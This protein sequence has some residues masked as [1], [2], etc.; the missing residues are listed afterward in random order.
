M[1][2]LAL[3]DTPAGW[4]RRIW[5]LTWPV[6]AANITIPLVGLVDTA[7]MG[8]LP[9]PAFMGAVAVGATVFSALYWIFGF[10]RMG[11]TALAAQAA[12]AGNRTALAAVALRGGSFA[13]LL[14]L[15]ILALQLPLLHLVRWM[16]QAS[17]EVESG[18]ATYFLIRVWG[19]P[20]L[21]LHLV[22]LG[23]LFGLQRMRAVL[24]L[25]ILMNLTN[26][27]LDL[28]LVPGLGWGVAGVATATVASEWLAMLVGARLL[29]RALGGQEVLRARHGLWA[30][31][32]LIRLAGMS[33]N[34]M[35]RSFF[36][37]LP[38]FVFTLVGASLGDL[39]LA[40][41]AILM[42][43]FIAMAY[44][45]DG[46]A[47]TAE[48]LCGYAYGA[49][50]RAGLRDATRHNL[51]WALGL[52]V[53]L[54][55]LM[56]VAG[57]HF[58]AWLTLL[59][60]VRAAAGTLLPWAVAAPL[61]AVWAF[62]LD[63]VFIGTGQARTLR[64]CMLLAALAYLLVI[65]AGL[66]PLGNSGLWLAMMVFMAL[67]GILLGLLYPGIERQLPAPQPR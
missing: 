45:L 67:R 33:G 19:A 18:A 27:A 49:A 37:Q 53:G 21:M 5:D 42:Q 16:F 26:I 64:N 63:G 34:L 47:H 8:R 59:P 66:G 32:S 51:R 41:N 55:L 57:E 20:A 36:V 48:T 39:V 35:V 52:A 1:N 25:S 4:R 6:V 44:I 9:D 46:P 60:D 10:L 50:D 31:G 40:A 22:V 29:Y 17:A 14:G 54:A 11:T 38:F 12:G 23:M 61:V 56:A 28:L 24:W 62:L 65:W 58:I 3:P 43:L 13:L 15:L 2:N 7:V 30:G